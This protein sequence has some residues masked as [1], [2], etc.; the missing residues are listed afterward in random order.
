MLMRSGAGVVAQAVVFWLQ[1]RSS[2][3]A[4]YSWSGSYSLA[5]P[6]THFIAFS[7]ALEVY[8]PSGIDFRV[9]FEA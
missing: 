5:S 1:I 9:R 3:F 4:A 6:L 7:L 2:L 8:H